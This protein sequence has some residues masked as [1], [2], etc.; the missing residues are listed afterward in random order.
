MS[1]IEGYFCEERAMRISR[2]DFVRNAV[3][4]ATVAAA[5]KAA[6]KP[7]RLESLAVVGGSRPSRY[8]MT[9]I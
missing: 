3:A 5:K 1:D 2:R 6:A 4:A 8:L 7:R 9:A